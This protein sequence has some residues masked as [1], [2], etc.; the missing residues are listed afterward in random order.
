[1]SGV[2]IAASKRRGAGSRRGSA[3]LRL[4]RGRRAGEAGSVAAELA[5]AAG[6]LLILLS[7]VMEFGMFIFQLI[8]LDSAVA[9]GT[10]F[11]MIHGSNP[12]VDP[13]TGTTY[14]IVGAMQ[15]GTVLGNNVCG[16]G[17]ICAPTAANPAV[18]C[19]CATATGLGAPVSCSTR[20]SSGFMPGKYQQATGQYNIV[21]MVLYQSYISGIMPNPA[22]K[23]GLVRIGQGP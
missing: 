20:C 23:S 22:G 6:F 2:R 14:S 8:E 12:F 21:T 19:Y 5:M 10:A 9:S 1:M 4:W 13:T 17:L 16:A 7:A 3:F 18:T 11:A 15:S